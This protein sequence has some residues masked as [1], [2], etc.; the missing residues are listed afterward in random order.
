MAKRKTAAR[1][2]EIRTPRR[3]GVTPTS[4]ELPREKSVIREYAEAL[5]F[6]LFL[7]LL[8]RSFI[9]QAFKIP[10]GSMLP[11]LQVG[12]HILVSKLHY[13]LRLPYPFEFPVVEWGAPQRGDIVVFVYPKDTSKDFIKRV[14]AVGGD[15]V[16]IHDKQLFVNGVADDSAYAYLANPGRI[17]RGPRDNYPAPRPDGTLDRIVVPDGKLFVMG[18][19]R[20][21]SHDSRFWGYVDAR[22]VKGK[23]L[24]I[25]WSWDGVDRWVRW[26]RLGSFIY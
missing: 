6:A 26:E 12:D 4:P 16:R 9:V 13:G 21:H 10:S 24:L 20:D 19:N 3:A 8:I 18:D 14:V 11:T 5:F 17:V 2:P 23:A 7:A 22:A 1:G 25:Y 15:E